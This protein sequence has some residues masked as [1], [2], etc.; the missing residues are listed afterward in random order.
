MPASFPVAAVTGPAAMKFPI[1][2][3]KV[4]ATVTV[5][6]PWRVVN[7][8]VPAMD[9]TGGDPPVM[10]KLPTVVPLR[11]RQDLGRRLWR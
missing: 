1:A 8:T 10:A 11:R 5:K 4:P 9:R 6:V 7:V 3:L 2:T